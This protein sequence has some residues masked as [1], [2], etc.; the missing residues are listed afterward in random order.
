M[1]NLKNRAFVVIDVATTGFRI[2]ADEPVEVAA[3][4]VQD[5]K[6][7]AH[8]VW[9]VE[10][11]VKIPPSASAIHEIR[12]EDTLGCPKLEEVE[13]EIVNFVGDLPIVMHNL[14]IGEPL[15][16]AMLP[17]LENNQW[18]CNARMTKHLWPQM[19]ENKGF[20]LANYDVWTLTYWLN[21]K[22]FDALGAEVYEPLA[23]AAATA[24]VFKH[25]VDE[26]LSRG[27][28]PSVEGMI[29]FSEKP[30]AF[31]LMPM[32]PY[33]NCLMS[34]LEP[35][36]LKFLLNKARTDETLDRDYKFTIEEESDRRLRA[37]GVS[38]GLRRI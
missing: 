30:V 32:G 16:K 29:E 8:Q 17:C 2:G 14:S 3:V 6:I 25:A 23:N 11:S 15:D 18:L 24:H 26:Y 7:L 20:P 1:E 19:T 28:E 13:H 22:G 9:R 31:K 33:K 36:Y 12:M 21:E 10:P 27:L 37:R 5:G 34:D 38:S 35:E 4:K